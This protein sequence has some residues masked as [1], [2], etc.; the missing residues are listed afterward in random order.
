[1][2]TNTMVVVSTELPNDK[3]SKRR[4][5]RRERGQGGLV[6]KRGSRNWYCSIEGL[7][8]LSREVTKNGEPLTV[9][10]SA[11]V[12]VMLRRIFRDAASPCSILRTSARNGS[13][14]VSRLD[15]GR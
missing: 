6:K 8:E 7:I 14:R 12:L 9:P 1:M 11:E 4:S 2:D 13:R 3:K 15:S 10:L 5:Y